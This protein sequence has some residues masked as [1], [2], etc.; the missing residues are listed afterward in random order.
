LLI[1][2]DLL[3]LEFTKFRKEFKSRNL[4]KKDNYRA[5]LEK[6][7]NEFT[8][9]VDQYI[10]G[11]RV[12][13]NS[14][15]ENKL[16][17][18]Y[19]NVRLLDTEIMSKVLSNKLKAY[20]AID[21]TTQEYDRGITDMSDMKFFDILLQTTD[22]EMLA[23]IERGKEMGTESGIIMQ[24]IL[25]YSRM[26]GDA[27]LLNNDH[28]VD[29]FA[30]LVIIRFYPYAILRNL[31]ETM[32]HIAPTIKNDCTELLKTK[33]DMF[34]NAVATV[35]GD[36]REYKFRSE[37]LESGD[38]V[39]G[40]DGR[41]A[42]AAAAGYDGRR[43]AAPANSRRGDGDGPFGSGAT[44]VAF[45][46]EV[47]RRGAVAVAPTNVTAVSPMLNTRSTPA[48][49]GQGAGM[50]DWVGR[51]GSLFQGQ[52]P[53][54]LPPAVGQ[55]GGA[56]GDTIDVIHRLKDNQWGRYNLNTYSINMFYKAIIL[57][58]ATISIPYIRFPDDANT[59]TANADAA[60]AA[61]AAAAI[62]ANYMTFIN[63]IKITT[64]SGYFS[65]SD[66]KY[67]LAD[68][69]N[70]TKKTIKDNINSFK[71]KLFEKL[72][73]LEYFR[74]V[75]RPPV[76]KGYPNFLRNV[77]SI[78]LNTIESTNL[79]SSSGRLPAPAAAAVPAPAAAAVPAPAA[80]AVKPKGR[81]SFLTLGSAGG[82]IT[83]KNR[84]KNSGGTRKNI[85]YNDSNDSNDSIVS[86]TSNDSIN[87]DSDL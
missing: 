9:Y 63:F 5:E 85:N 1:L 10:Q 18:F 56:Q 73:D 27:C 41:G 64:E 55:G 62:D 38:A 16:L 86:T 52:P 30:S 14:E 29:V 58:S 71:D 77:D 59:D 31:F 36:F 47:S 53:T 21:K 75:L 23:A 51:V 22:E 72:D 33:S 26:N 8:T 74:N 39:A 40:D 20:M 81:F 78:I 57:L 11:V 13:Y 19:S 66:M 60:A 68:S 3:G 45:A 61:A 6:L 82:Q 24:A 34:I 70:A 2:T 32:R 25:R 69:D 46:P 42:A 37:N 65:E 67:Y 17:L 84:K 43:A 7:F 80:A 50:F 48:D 49:Q 79:F 76:N 12:A 35:S 83:K 54:G 28:F 4:T 44:A 87:N 15:N